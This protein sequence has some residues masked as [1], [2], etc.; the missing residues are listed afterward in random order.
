M[1]THRITVNKTNVDH[2]HYSLNGANDVMVMSGNTADITAAEGTNT[3]VVKGVNS[4]HAV[5]DTDSTTFEYSTG[6]Q[7]PP[8]QS[9]VTCWQASIINRGAGF[10]DINAIK[11]LFTNYGWRDFYE[12]SSFG[13]PNPQVGVN[14]AYL[15]R[16]TIGG[17]NSGLPSGTLGNLDA[18]GGIERFCMS[19]WGIDVDEDDDGPGTHFFYIFLEPQGGSTDQYKLWAKIN[20]YWNPG[21]RR[22]GHSVFQTTGPDLTKIHA[23]IQYSVRVSFVGD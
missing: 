1:S 10:T 3:I 21:W 9:P 22:G 16:L 14:G 2:W 15:A 6:P 7:Q 17:G 20:N 11:N 4:G 13:Y 12:V 23:I 18:N 5:L 19:N 8:N